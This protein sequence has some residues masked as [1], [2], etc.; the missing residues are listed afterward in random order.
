V[1]PFY[2]PRVIYRFRVEG[3]D[4]QGD[5]LG[6]MV[7]STTREVAERVLAPFPVGTRVAVHYDPREPTTAVVA[8]RAGMLPLVLAAIAAVLGLV[9]YALMVL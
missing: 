5:Q 1:T 7:S 3:V 6:R 4:V 8:P 2:I 9:A